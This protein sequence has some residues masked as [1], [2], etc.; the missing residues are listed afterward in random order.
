MRKIKDFIHRLL[1]QVKV[2]IL[3]FRKKR[4]EKS[5]FRKERITVV[6]FVLYDNMWKNDGLF[7]FLLKDS[8]FAPYIVSSPYPHHPRLFSEE[9]QKRVECFFKKKGYPY[10]NGYDFADD[11][12]FDIKGLEPDIV[13]YQQPYNTGFKGFLIESLCRNTIFGYIPY[14]YTLEDDPHMYNTL[15]FNI[16]WKVFLPSEFEKNTIKDFLLT[17]GR[18][19]VVTGHL[20]ADELIKQGGTES[21]PWKDK[22]HTL[23]RVIWAPHHSILDEDSLNCSASFV[24]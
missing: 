20:L 6:F 1:F 17:N 5:I 7:E 16:A 22:T 14:C 24:V 4:L 23:K 11:K 3:Y 12:W 2:W 18:N 9:N 19:L 8:R 21:I 10:F 15:L 13:F